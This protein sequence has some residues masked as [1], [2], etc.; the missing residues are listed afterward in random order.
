MYFLFWW[1]SYILAKTVLGP[2]ET[3]QTESFSN[4]SWKLDE[5]FNKRCRVFKYELKS[6]GY[7]NYNDFSQNLTRYEKVT[8]YRSSV[9]IIVWSSMF[10]RMIQCVLSYNAV[11]FIVWSSVFFHMIQC[12]FSYDPVCFI[13]WSSVFFHM[14]QCVLSYDPLGAVRGVATAGHISLHNVNDIYISPIHVH[15]FHYCNGTNGFCLPSLVIW[16]IVKNKSN[17]W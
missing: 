4:I 1:I 7:S 5:S 16:L 9:F 10:Y 15:Y 14:I 3:A 6:G 8:F 13:V 2:E 11:C 12:V 17:Q